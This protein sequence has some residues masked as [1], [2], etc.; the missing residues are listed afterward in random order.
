MR[1]VRN[2]PQLENVV[3]WASFG[4]CPMEY[5]FWLIYAGAILVVAGVIGLAFQRTV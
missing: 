4:G 3:A 5:P 1:L 2:S